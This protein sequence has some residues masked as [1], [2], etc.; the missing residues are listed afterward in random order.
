M[1][2]RYGRAIH[3]L[4]ISVT[5]N[6]N[7]NCRYCRPDN[8][9]IR[10]K[11]SMTH[12][13][14]VR[15]AAIAAKQGIRSIRFTGGEPLL[16]Q[17]LAAIIYDINRIPQIEDVSVTTNGVFFTEQ[18]KELKAAGLNR[19]NFSLDTFRPERFSYMTGQDDLHKVLA[20]IEQSIQI[21]LS[22]TKINTVVLRGFN[23][24][25]LLDFAAF[26]YKMP[27]HVRFIECMPIGNLTFY[28]QEKTVSI[29]D[30]KQILAQHYTL[31]PFAEVAGSGPAEYVRLRG[32]Q[33][34]IGFIG[35]LSEHFCAECNRL[36][37]TADG[38]LRS[39]LFAKG[40]VDLLTELRQGAQ[41]QDLAELFRLAIR[42]KPLRHE[43]QSGW[44]KNNRRM[45]YQI[46]G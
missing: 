40:E 37:L 22:P 4:R 12:Q 39:C 23:D 41:D 8:Q 30:M 13:E 24:D 36:R 14:I 20:A 19:V 34:T 26:A 5:E 43:M 21:G 15:F 2:D 46:G 1:L 31:D 35:A 42:K 3:Y 33:G 45:M 18:A 44:G 7:L 17:D 6:C 28:D 27:L 16:R 38:K 10:Q 11:K 9:F 29:G 25:E 32:G